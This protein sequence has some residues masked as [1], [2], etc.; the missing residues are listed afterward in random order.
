MR[1]RIAPWLCLLAVALCVLAIDLGFELAFA[2]SPPELV[3]YQLRTRTRMQ[4]AGRRLAD[5][6]HDH[7]DVG[8]A[9]GLSSMRDGFDPVQMTLHDAKGRW[10]TDLAGAGG[11]THDLQFTAQ[12]LLEYLRV[13]RGDASQVK[14]VIVGLHAEWLA[15]TDP[16]TV[17]RRQQWNDPRSELEQALWITRN[18]RAMGAAVRYWLDRARGSFLTA[19]GQGPAAIYGREDSHAPIWEKATAPLSAAELR[20]QIEQ[21]SEDGWF[22]PHRYGSA[23]PRARV[24]A[25]LLVELRDADVDLRV[26]YMPC[27]SGWRALT[28]PEASAQLVAIVASVLPPDRILDLRAALPDDRFADYSHLRAPGRAALTERL[29]AWLDQRE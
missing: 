21:W 3:R 13:H 23:G 6:L 10:W 14:V 24:L 28:P 11:S 26:V 27:H 9:L 1:A 29:A 25:Q 15:E 8:I 2:P 18:G 7:R 19:A 5:A 22:E 16:E 20:M 12:P 17:L 4:L